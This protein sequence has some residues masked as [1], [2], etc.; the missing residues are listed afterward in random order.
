MYLQEVHYCTLE[1]AAWLLWYM[2][3]LRRR[4]LKTEGKACEKKRVKKLKLFI[5][6]LLH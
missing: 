6:N 5:P 4:L 1:G 3:W 2:H